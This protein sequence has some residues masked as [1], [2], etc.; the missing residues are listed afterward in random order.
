MNTHDRIKY[1]K[2]Q[3]QLNYQGYLE[4]VCDYKGPPEERYAFNKSMG[5]AHHEEIKIFDA[6]IKALEAPIVSMLEHDGRLMVATAAPSGLFEYRNGA[7]VW[8]NPQVS[9][10]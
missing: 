1:L 2:E 5:K 6:E 7:L 9:S 8:L 3:I 10:P 4:K